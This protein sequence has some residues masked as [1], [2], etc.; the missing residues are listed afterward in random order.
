MSKGRQHRDLRDVAQPDDGVA[1]GG[2]AAGRHRSSSSCACVTRTPWSRVLRADLRGTLAPFFLASLSPMAMAC[3]RLLTLAPEPL[4][5]VPFFLRCIADFTV[6]A[7][8]FPY[9]A[10]AHLRSNVLQIIC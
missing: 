5:S 8:D 7:A 2:A 3:L 1:D 4:L 6:F 10:N 9:F